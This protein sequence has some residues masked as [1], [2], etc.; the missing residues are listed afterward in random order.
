MTDLNAFLA[1]YGVPGMKWGKRKGETSD[2]AVKKTPKPV[3]TQAQQE[4]RDAI[5]GYSLMAGGI[6]VATL[7]PRVMEKSLATIS[8]V[9]DRKVA[10][11]GEKIMNDIFSDKRGIT[12]Y[13]TLELVRDTAGTWRK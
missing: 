5:I 9:H 2:A 8:G 13:K 10:A 12:N 6:A 11:A 7:G 1:H 4:R 3:R